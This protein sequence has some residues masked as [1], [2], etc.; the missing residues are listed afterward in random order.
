MLRAI[1]LVLCVM[2]AAQ[3]ATESLSIIPRP[4]VARRLNGNFVAGRSVVVYADP[5]A[6]AVAQWFAETLRSEF[7][8]AAAV[9]T[10]PSRRSA[11][12]FL[13][14]TSLPEE[15]YSLRIEPRGVT[16]HGHPAGLFYGG[17]SLLQ[18]A[19]VRSHSAFVLP[20]A[21][22]QDQPRFRYRGLHLDTARHM[23]PVEFLKQYLDWMARYKLNRFHWHL[24]DDQGWR[25]EIKQYP[26]LSEIAS[27][28]KETL[29]GRAPQSSRY[30]GHPY[31]GF[32]TQEQI[33]EV[34]AYAQER[35][36]TV[37]PEIE[38]PGHSLAALSAYPELACTPGPFE[39]ATTWGGFKDVYC[40]KPGTFQFLENVLTEVMDLFPSPYLHI[41]G[42]EVQKDRWKESADAQAVIR[43][44]GLKDESELQSYFIRRMEQFINSKGRRM[45]GWD[46]I[47]EGGLAPDATV[48]SWRGEDGGIE[49]ARQG[50][51]VIM[52]PSKYLYFDY[53]Q[54]DRNKEPLAIGGMLPLEKVYSYNPTPAALNAQEKT[55]I[56]GAQAN[57]WTEYMADPQQVEYMLFPRLFALAEVAWSP[58]DARNYRDF[59][60]RVPP[61]LARLKRQ[62]VNYR[63]LEAPQVSKRRK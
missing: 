41:G 44:A 57:M 20:A 43:N 50:H 48:M 3:G 10:E 51:D 2:G 24:T 27:M 33:R 4:T 12:R 38:M 59:L 52:T 49:A 22:I 45:I 16:V 8:L 30:D 29:V 55:H 32:Y 62:G 63:P 15:G 18:L 6:R 28:R 7:G 40:P 46:E 58:Q 1:W 21:E 17:Q 36:I 5:D 25:I 54:G 34:V 14:D 60:H 26:R 19:A 61:Q 42:D 31:G 9:T 23:F 56:L 47:L 11:F 53:Y 39:A 13:S 37:I 35:F